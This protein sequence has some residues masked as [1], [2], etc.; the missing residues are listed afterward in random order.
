MPHHSLPSAAEEHSGRRPSPAATSS[1]SGTHCRWGC[2]GS[3][4][5]SLEGMKTPGKNRGGKR[6]KHLWC[7]YSIDIP[8][9]FS[10]FH[11]QRRLAHWSAKTV[12]TVLPGEIWPCFGTSGDF[13]ASFAETVD[14][15]GQCYNFAATHVHTEIWCFGEGLN[16]VFADGNDFGWTDV[17]SWHWE[18]NQKAWNSSTMHVT[19]VVVNNFLSFLTPLIKLFE[20]DNDEFYCHCFCLTTEG[21]KVGN[22]AYMWWNGPLFFPVVRGF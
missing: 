20:I 2:T 7:T 16:L 12:P 9:G 4:W 19:Y 6:K 13:S 3:L 14:V 21:R 8:R 17:W 10:S 11:L 18:R 1:T 22:I 5:G 15:L